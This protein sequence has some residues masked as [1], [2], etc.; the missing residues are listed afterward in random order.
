MEF[1]GQRAFLVTE[2][3]SK[4]V[5]YNIDQTSGELIEIETVSLYSHNF[6]EEIVKNGETQYPAEIELHPNRKWMYV[7]NRGLGA[8]FMFDVSGDRVKRG[9]TILTDGNWP[10][11]FSIRPDGKFLI[12]SQQLTNSLEIYSIDQVLCSSSK[13]M[14]DS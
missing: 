10:R 5:I 7:S 11:H 12:V 14:Y 4:L 13:S 8:V 1:D 3:D 9:P 2:L 6:E